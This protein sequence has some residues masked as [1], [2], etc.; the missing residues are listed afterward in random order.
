MRQPQRPV[1]SPSSSETA[2]PSSFIPGAMSSGAFLTRSTAAA[3]SSSS[4]PSCACSTFAAGLPS[5]SRPMMKQPST[6]AGS[7]VPAALAATQIWAVGSS[8]QALPRKK[9]ISTPSWPKMHSARLADTHCGTTHT[10]LASCADSSTS[11]SA[12][13]SP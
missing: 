13:S 8:R 7:V 11:S 1:R 6:F 3:P 10:G 5:H 2:P 9:R 12:S 4:G